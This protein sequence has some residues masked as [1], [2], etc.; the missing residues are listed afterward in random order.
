MQPSHRFVLLTATL[1]GVHPATPA[2]AETAVEIPRTA[3]EHLCT[4]LPVPAKGAPLSSAVQAEANK[5]GAD[6]WQLVSFAVVGRELVVCLAR[7]GFAA[8]AV[9]TRLPA[10]APRP[11]L[12]GNWT[13]LDADE[14]SR[15]VVADCFAQPT[16]LK[17]KSNATIRVRAV[18]NKTDEHL[19]NGAI[20]T[21]FETAMVASRK[22][23]V[24]AREDPNDQAAT[25][26]A[27]DYA[28]VV[29]I[30]SILDQV[31]GLRIKAYDVNAQIVDATTGEVACVARA[32]VKKAVSRPAS[33]W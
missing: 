5:R 24:L 25:A 22:I 14:T 18:I 19:D 23:R 30:S 16:W 29:R 20:A 12:S 15:K 8:N 33:V 7:P 6:G 27:A 32:E 1:V 9:V 2:R 13:E 11:E 28:L 26:A 31:E 17:G 3:V 4:S 10:D 21:K